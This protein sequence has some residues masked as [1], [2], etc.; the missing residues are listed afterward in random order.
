MA[1]KLSQ[2][3]KTN[4]QFK[5]IF[6]PG[7]FFLTALFLIIYSF[8]LQADRQPFLILLVAGLSYL[9]YLIVQKYGITL[10]LVV[11]LVLG[12]SIWAFWSQKENK[13]QLEQARSILVYPDQVKIKNGFL[14]GIASADRQKIAIAGPVKVKRQDDRAYYLTEIDGQLSPIEEP[15]N[16]GQFNLKQYYQARNIKQQLKF[17]SCRLIPVAQRSWRLQ[18]HQLRF[19]LLQRCLEMPKLLGFFASELILGEKTI[20]ETNEILANYQSL[21]IIHLLSISGLHV[22]IYTLILST[23][24][25][26]LKITEKNCFYFCLLLLILLVFLCDFQSGFVRATLMYFWAHFFKF[27]G[28]KITSCDLLGLT[29]ICHLFWC[30][31]LF[32]MTGAILS[33]I[34]VLGINLSAELAPFKQTIVLN[35]IL[36]PFL[37]FY[38]YQVNLLTVFF[39]LLAVP[40]FN[41]LVLPLSMLNFFCFHLLP[42]AQLSENILSLTENLL[43][44]LAQSK[45]GLITLGQ[46]KLWQLFLLVALTILAFLFWQNQQLPRARLAFMA[47]ITSYLAFFLTIHF[48]LWGQVT[49]IDVGQGDSILITTP[50]NRKSF[51]IDTG[52]KLNFTGHKIQPQFDRLTL[53]FL[54]AQGITQLDGVFISH[55]DADHCGD[56]SELLRQV[57]VKKLYLAQGLIDN[58]N[59]RKR[60]KNRLHR[61]QIVELLAG[62][63]LATSDFK[64]QVVYP[65]K[66]GSGKNEDS[67]SL[68]IRIAEKNWLF[69]GDLDQQGEEKILEKYPALQVDYFKLGHHGSKTASSPKFLAAIKPQLT[70]ISAGVNNRFGHP[71]PETIQ[72]LRQE[73]IPYVST[74]DYGMITWK[75]GPSTRPHF[76]YFLKGKRQ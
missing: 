20:T 56:L 23:I 46:I 67:L 21:G 13:L 30:P 28:R 76:E 29:A 3:S 24:C 31:K 62:S 51:L 53:H 73:G 41:Y 70:F 54:R 5:D 57:K 44:R 9:L 34:L 4:L 22:G 36:T 63:S 64:L 37:L 58:P 45:L 48:P 17:K 25:Y 10:K 35:C 27:T 38:F 66:A 42:I 39:N 43:S 49:F 33:Y 71:H 16:R 1:T 72:T 15:R 52:G 14:M 47:L 74:Q 19:H 75:Y 11:F 40:Y 50:L 26:F 69:T 2:L 32:M 12:W 61:T 65:F 60:I 55:Q 18:F 8:L 68:L 6:C 7:F 59:F